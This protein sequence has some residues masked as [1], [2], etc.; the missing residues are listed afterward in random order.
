MI[1]SKPANKSA[2]GINMKK[3]IVLDEY[4]P[5]I[6]VDG[7]HAFPLGSI[8]E[9]VAGPDEDGYTD[10]LIRRNNGSTLIQ[11]LKSHQFEILEGV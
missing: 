1:G 9:V 6:V 11:S 10:L 4:H 7:W 5:N 3:A 8:V 2:T